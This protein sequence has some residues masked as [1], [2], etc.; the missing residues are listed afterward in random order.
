MVSNDLLTKLNSYVEIKSYI[1][2]ALYIICIQM[3]PKMNVIVISLFS[4]SRLKMLV[5]I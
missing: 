2:V 3:N 4:Q 1:F 5:L